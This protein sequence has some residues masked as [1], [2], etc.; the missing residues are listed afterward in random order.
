VESTDVP[1]AEPEQQQALSIDFGRYL[2]AFRKYAWVLAAM[3]VLAITG[4]VIYTTRQT[5]IYEATASLQIEPRLPDLLG[6]GDL[7][8][9][10]AGGGNAAEYY[11]QQR[12]V[13]G[14]F[15]L[16]QT[17]ITENDLVPRITSEAERKDLSQPEVLELA[18][19]R[20]QKAIT[21]KYPK[22]NHIMYIG[23]RSADAELA[24]QIANAHV[25]TYINYAK[26]LLSMNSEQAS[27]KLQTDF[28]DAEQKLRQA[29]EK[30]YKFLADNNMI[31]LTLETQQ[32]L[33][34]SNILAFTQKL[35]DARADEIALAAKLAQ[36]KRQ[37]QLDVL[38]SPIVMMADDK[39]SFATLREQYYTER[40]HLL[41]LQKD[42]GVKNPDYIAQKEKVDE[43]YKALATEVQIIA[44][45]TRDLHTVAETTSQGLAAEVEKY[46]AEAR[47]LSPKIGVYNDLLRQKKEYE[48][49][50][51][52]LRARLSTTQM[53]GSM[54]SIISNVRDLDPALLPTKPISPDMRKNVGIVIALALVLGIGAI[55]L[56]VFLD[57]SIKS[58]SDASQSAGVP[59]L[60]MIPVL[61]GDELPKDDDRS[62]DMFVHEHPTSH[63]AECCRSLRTNILFS[64]ADRNL[65]TILVCSANQREGKTTSVIYL[66][67][68]MAQSGQKVLLIDTDLRR[69][70][71]HASTGVSKTRGLSNLILGEDDYDS[72]I[73]ATDIPNL[74][75][76]PCGTVP[77]NPA[78]LLMTKR[79]EQVLAD[80]KKR[81]TRI[82]LDSPPLGPVTDA[83]VLS[84]RVDGVVLV[85]RAGKT[86][87]D[88]LKRSS[89]QIRDVGGQ[90][91]GVIVNEFDPSSVG[92]YYGY[93]GYYGYSSQER[94]SPE[95]A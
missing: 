43:L 60:G 32:S 13:L 31:A 86:L 26:G 27:E 18:T 62:R 12:E 40:N 46:K 21:I 48:D 83:V 16:V 24:K 68:T 65:D 39:S 76:L 7:F 80:L 47:D 79:F 56:I 85:C 69:P 49:K 22:P 89:E 94:E 15:T 5:P 54:S 92:S 8:N 59:V 88:E 28:N 52:I 93:Y 36:I 51:T 4:A 25:K 90:I 55:F 75:V 30:I 50:Y 41:E 78:E 63:V 33:V 53:T 2:A 84:R 71:L 38:Q 9:V 20:L 11:N 44:D 45:G 87:R 23:V 74:Y 19:R 10:A 91:V 70:R 67:T 37:A 77:P 42:L 64:A 66:G 29:E 72:V 95:A 17:T 57:R 81:F 6:T 14:S 82:I 58:T 73:K 34:S 1:S 3:V 35:N 61:G